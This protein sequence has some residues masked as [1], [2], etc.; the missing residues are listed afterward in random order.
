MKNNNL[1]AVLA[2]TT[3]LFV[4]S[5][6]KENEEKLNS[7]S[8]S[9]SEVLEEE[10][11]V[12]FSTPT[13]YANIFSETDNS[14]GYSSLK[15]SLEDHSIK[16]E[17][18]VTPTTSANGKLMTPTIYVNG[19]AIGQNGNSS[20]RTAKTGTHT[21][22]IYGKNIKFSVSY[23]QANARVQSQEVDMYV[24]NLVEI[25]NP[26][27]ATSEE[28][29]PVV[30][31]DDFVLEW[32]AD[33]KNQEGLIVVV[34]YSGSC[35][36]QEDNVKKHIQNVGLIEEDNG[37]TILDAALFEGIPDMSYAK[38]TLLR[39][40]IDIQEIDG[41][42]YKFFAETHSVLPFILAY[43][44]SHLEFYSDEE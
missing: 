42:L 8:N 22:D 9:Q 21:N 14:A 18:H 5:C 39:G 35:V 32:N 44:E 23:G 15:N 4:V 43:D 6:N 27:V 2:F 40:N 24:P 29:M 13:K 38:L 12:T 33:T 28:M 31:K 36:F 34:E 7:A 37:Q 20:L 16:E 41:G 17:V 11:N 19:Q 26:L 1:I 30:M 25:T 10:Y 3:S